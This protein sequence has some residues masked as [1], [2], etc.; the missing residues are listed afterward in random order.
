VSILLEGQLFLRQACE[1]L[2]GEDSASNPV[3]WI[4]REEEGGDEKETEHP[5]KYL[6]GLGKDIAQSSR[7]GREVKKKVITRLEMRG[8][9]LGLSEKNKIRNP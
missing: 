8:E 6:K 7:Y 9:K 1:G 4:F 2:T 3:E 5:S